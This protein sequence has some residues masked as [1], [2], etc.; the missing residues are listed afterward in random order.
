MRL[1]LDADACQKVSYLPTKKWWCIKESFFQ[2]LTCGTL[3]QRSVE[4][5]K[6]NSLFVFLISYADELL[7]IFTDSADTF[8]GAA[9]DLQPV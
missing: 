2:L 1:N 8:S 4:H 3:M 7:S 6:L 9:L 5:L